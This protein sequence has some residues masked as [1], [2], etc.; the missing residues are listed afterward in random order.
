LVLSLNFYI[1]K[2]EEYTLPLLPSDID[3]KYIPEENPDD[4]IFRVPLFTF[5]AP[6]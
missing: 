6:E 2:K 1:N 5:N 4:T 3:I